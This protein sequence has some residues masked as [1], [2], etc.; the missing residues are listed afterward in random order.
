M[1]DIDTVIDLLEPVFTGTPW[2]PEGTEFTTEVAAYMKD[3]VSYR[4]PKIVSSEPRNL[5]CLNVT[6]LTH[7]LE[8]PFD[9]DT[10][11]TKGPPLEGY[12]FFHK[13][14]FLIRARTRETAIQASR[15]LAQAQ[16]RYMDGCSKEYWMSIRMGEELI[17]L[18][19]QRPFTEFVEPGVPDEWHSVLDQYFVDCHNIHLDADIDTSVNLQC[20]LLQHSDE[21]PFVLRVGCI[22]SFQMLFTGLVA[23][24]EWGRFGLSDCPPELTRMLG[25]RD[26]C[27]SVKP[28]VIHPLRCIEFYLTRSAFWETCPYKV[29][30]ELTCDES[31]PIMRRVQV[32][33]GHPV[34]AY[35]IEFSECEFSDEASLAPR[36][37]PSVTQLRFTANEDPSL[38]F[39][40][41]A[42]ELPCRWLTDTTSSLL[43]P[44][45]DANPLDPASLFEAL[46]LRRDSINHSRLEC[47]VFDLQIAS[48][49]PCSCVLT[50][51]ALSTNVFLRAVPST[52]LAFTP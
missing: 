50:F 17:R 6:E 39:E 21:H 10:A 31:Y 33:F 37:L 32:G 41:D 35:L 47:V 4:P 11:T 27:I 23:A 7:S 48:P 16:L 5:P 3:Y 49:E 22:A 25:S 30:L 28:Y 38:S 45:S 8:W 29:S 13:F 24:S 51:T 26:V 42:T 20:P 19:E 43:L 1:N 9:A 18:V 2:R 15:L 36:V 52:G 46:F 12:H 40:R 44:L 14:A 34:V